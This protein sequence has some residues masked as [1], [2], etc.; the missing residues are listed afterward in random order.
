MGRDRKVRHCGDCE[1]FFGR[2]SSNNRQR[3]PIAAGFSSL[4]PTSAVD[5]RKSRSGQTDNPHRLCRRCA[6]VESF[7]SAEPSGRSTGRPCSPSRL[8]DIGEFQRSRLA[9][10]QLDAAVGQPCDLSPSAVRKLL[11]Q[12]TECSGRSGWPRSAITRYR[13]RR[14]GRGQGRSSPFACFTAE[15]IGNGPF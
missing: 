10:C 2:P 12:A 8:G 5:A 14:G 3:M 11:R 4:G 6:A 15:I 1:A 9:R 7:L 13:Q